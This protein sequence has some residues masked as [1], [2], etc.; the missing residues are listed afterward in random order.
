MA[1]D[2]FHYLITAIKDLVD[3]KER[4]TEEQYNSSVESYKKKIAAFVKN[5]NI[6]QEQADSLIK[7][8]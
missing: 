3:R 2:I 4:M 7:M 1:R 6:T 5:G 8:M